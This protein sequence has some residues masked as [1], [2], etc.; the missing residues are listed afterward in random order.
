MFEDSSFRRH[1]HVDDEGF[2]SIKIYECNNTTKSPE[3]KIWKSIEVLI[4]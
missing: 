2:R 3:L 1:I 4:T